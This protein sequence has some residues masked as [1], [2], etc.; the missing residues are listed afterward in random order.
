MRTPAP[1]LLPIFRSAHQA[2]L[3]TWLYLRPGEEFTLSDLSRRLGVSG[4]SLHAEVERLVA[5]GLIIDRRV[6]RNRMIQANTATRTVRAL[7][8]LLT[9]TYGPQVVIAE[10]FADLPGVELVLIYGS[11]ARRFRGEVGRE[12]ADVDVMVVG[13]VDRDSVYEAAERAERR[14]ELPVNTT[15]RS[16]AAWRKEADA[17]VLTA[18]PDA[19]TVVDHTR[20]T[21]SEGDVS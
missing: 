2:A 15:V 5:A 11:W 4:G 12:P 14:L 6:G 1:A 21:P 10:E 13:S 18:K 20:A 7:T 3:L 8:E 9:V 16:V 17:L 19:V